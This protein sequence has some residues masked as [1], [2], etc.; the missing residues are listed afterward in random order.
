MEVKLVSCSICGKFGIKENVKV[1][2]H[3]NV[4]LCAD[5]QKKLKP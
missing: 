5:C 3:C 1:C 4:A 2:Q